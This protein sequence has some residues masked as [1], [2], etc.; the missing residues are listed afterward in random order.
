MKIHKNEEITSFYNNKCEIL[1]N[2]L[3]IFLKLYNIIVP[4]SLIFNFIIYH[5]LNK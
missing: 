2:N 1:N 3:R 5:Y 4:S